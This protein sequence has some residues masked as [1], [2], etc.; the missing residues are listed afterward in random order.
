MFRRLNNQ[1]WIPSAHLRAQVGPR[2]RGLD[3]AEVASIPEENLDADV[4]VAHYSLIC[5]ESIET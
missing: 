2:S 1:L 4:L 5:P 3:V